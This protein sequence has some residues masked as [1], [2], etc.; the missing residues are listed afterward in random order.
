[1]SLIRS[2]HTKP[3]LLF[4]KFLRLIGAKHK[5]QPKLFGK[6]DFLLDGRIVIFIDSKFWH[7]KGNLPKHNRNYWLF[8]L[9][10]NRKRDFLV[11]KILRKEGYKV[12]RIE[13]RLIMRLFKNL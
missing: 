1:M 4:R 9:S 5:Y 2:T 3:E 13:D 10:R 7:G 6:P 8:K 11:N 12:I